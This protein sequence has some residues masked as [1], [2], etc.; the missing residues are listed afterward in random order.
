MRGLVRPL[1]PSVTACPVVLS[2]ESTCATVAD[3]ARFRSSAQ[4]PVTCGAAIEVP[5]SGPKPFGGVSREEVIDTPGA[6]RF[7]NDAEFEKFATTSVLDVAPTLTAVEMQPGADMLFVNPS[8]PDEMTVAMPA[9]RRLSMN[10]LV[11]AFWA[12]QLDCEKNWPPPRLMFTAAIEKLVRRL[13]TCCRALL[14]LET[15]AVVHGLLSPPAAHCD[16]EFN[17]EKTWTAMI[18]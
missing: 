5:S 2:A 17:C 7:K 14:M 18:E 13:K 15:N 6:S 1:R 11:D 16:I 4:A 10:A 12:S 8:L 9:A 3:G